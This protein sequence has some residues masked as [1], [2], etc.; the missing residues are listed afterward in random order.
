MTDTTTAA[1]TKSP[2]QSTTIQGAIVA[3]FSAVAPTLAARLG[4]QA[5]DLIDVVSAL[6]TIVGFAMTVIGRMK[7]T[8]K[9][10]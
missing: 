8:K 9:I 10:A 2:L 1:D 4:V 6:G 3:I 7:A 5:S